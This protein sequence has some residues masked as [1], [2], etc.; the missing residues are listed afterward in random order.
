[1]KDY[2][3]KMVRQKRPKGK[4]GKCRDTAKATIVKNGI[5]RDYSLGRWGSPEAEQAY[6]R[7]LADYYSDAIPVSSSS[8]PMVVFLDHYNDYAEPLKSDPGR[9][10]TKKVLRLA[11]LTCGDIPCSKFNFSTITLLKERIVQEAIKN[12]W[13]KAYANQLL[14]IW[15]KI[16]VY[17]VLNG[18]LDSNLLP[19]ITSYPPITENLKPLATREAVNDDYVER[20]LK[21]TSAR[22]ADI[23]RLIRSACL[24]P[25]ELLRLKK[26]DIQIKE[27]KWVAYIPSKTKRFGYSRIVV[28]TEKEV[29]ILQR[30]ITDDDLIF[31]LNAHS[32]SV[33]VSK[34][35]KKANE[36]GEN[37]PKWTPYQLRHAAFTENVEKYGVEVAAKLA[38]HSSLN[39]AKIYDHSTEGILLKLAE[40]R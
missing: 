30:W 39:M 37:I 8:E 33:I 3:G 10:R 36:N 6:K 21:Y 15:K 9:Y 26:S 19:L 34:A 2:A 40:L 38:G 16:L 35:I 22:N 7:L 29:E 18:W 4:D 23:I 11:L 28:F 31:K 13:T 17:G 12:G 32:L 24:R 5:K 1:M 27:G 20:T 14:S 25:T